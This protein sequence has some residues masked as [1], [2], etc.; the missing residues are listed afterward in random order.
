MSS[1][2]PQQSPTIISVVFRN[3]I[4]NSGKLCRITEAEGPGPTYPTIQESLRFVGD[5]TT[6]QWT[7]RLRDNGTVVVVKGGKACKKL[8]GDEKFSVVNGRDGWQERK[9][10]MSETRTRC[11]RIYES[12]ESGWV[13]GKLQTLA[14]EP[15]SNNKLLTNNIFNK[16]ELTL[17]AATDRFRVKDEDEQKKRMTWKR[18]KYP[19]L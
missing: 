6:S 18:T 14:A 9:C 7:K 17:R 8:A 1:R 10:A 11:G 19:F 2:T 16:R 3:P 15:L 5:T 13:G 12:A 4:C